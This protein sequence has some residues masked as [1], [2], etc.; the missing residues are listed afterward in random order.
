MNVT[1]LRL[2]FEEIIER[3]PNL[4]DRFYQILFTKY[5]QVRPLFRG[6]TR[7]QGKMLA[8]ALGAVMDHLEDAAWLVPTLEALGA[9][10]VQY[11]VTDEMYGWVGESLLG[12]LADVAGADWNV[13]LIVAWSEAFTFIANT[14]KAGAARAGAA[15]A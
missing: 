15:A 14:M 7:A 6:D 8:G 4:A 1:L 5:P 13:D 9:R 12:A 10:H 11:G 2:S 3:E